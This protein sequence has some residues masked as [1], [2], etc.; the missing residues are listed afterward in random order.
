MCDSINEDPQA[1]RR[2]A[3]LKTTYLLKEFNFAS[4]GK[5]STV[6]NCGLGHQL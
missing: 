4:Q 2:Y 6:S 1:K 3:L 5:H